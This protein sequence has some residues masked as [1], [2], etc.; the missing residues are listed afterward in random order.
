MLMSRRT[1]DQLY[2]Q[3]IKNLATKKS[4]DIGVRM[5]GSF[6]QR[7]RMSKSSGGNSG[8]EKYSSCT[9]QNPTLRLYEQEPHH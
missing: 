3:P 7:E 2:K 5:I 8:H 4:P 6:A 9:D 1:R